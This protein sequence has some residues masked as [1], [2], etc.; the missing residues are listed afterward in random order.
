MSWSNFAESIYFMEYGLWMTDWLCATDFMSRLTESESPGEID[1]LLRAHIKLARA[2]PV[3]A[4]FDTICFISA[5]PIEI[6]HDEKGLLHNLTGPAL[7]Y[8]DGFEVYAFHGISV[9]KRFIVDLE[10]VHPV[11]ILAE[12]NISRLHILIDVYGRDR[13]AKDVVELKAITPLDILNEKNLARR[14]L[15]V[16]LYGSVRY[17]KDAFT[18]VWQEDETGALYRQWVDLGQDIV[19]LKVT[20][21]T[22][23]PDGSYDEH[24]LR[25]PPDMQTARL[26]PGH[27]VW[28]RANIIRLSRLKLRSR[29]VPVLERGVVETKSA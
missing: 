12:T 24:W 4:A 11:D 23:N 22:Q 8:Q 19:F 9:P 21:S 2:A 20:N 7:T 3:C 29:S 13:F 28:R 27:S 25:V 10:S 5:R 14:R 16:Q 1:K 15:L 17:V 6:L 26:L 18:Q